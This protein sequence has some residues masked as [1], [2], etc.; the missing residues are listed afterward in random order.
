MPSSPGK[1]PAPAPKPA[2]MAPKVEK[3]EAEIIFQ[4]FFKSVGPRTYASQI[5][6]AGNGNHFLVLTEGKRDDKTGEVRKT[7]VFVF[8]EDFG[9]F[10]R[11]L[12]ET[13]QFIKA[14]PVSEEVRRKREKF[15]AKKAATNG[16]DD[17]MDMEPLPA[18]A[19]PARAAPPSS[20]PIRPAPVRPAPVRPAQPS[21]SNRAAPAVVRAAQRGQHLLA[22]RNDRIVRARGEVRFTRRAGSATFPALWRTFICFL[23]GVL[24]RR[25]SP[26]ESRPAASR[27]LACW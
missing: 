21:A 27:T 15:W 2:A 7:R 5:K 24:W 6:R 8:S 25:G 16:D 26:R 4:K 22:R 23:L 1:R 11:M 14:N 3:P 10:F 9:A 20:A 13:A 18:R 17:L 19:A 12:H